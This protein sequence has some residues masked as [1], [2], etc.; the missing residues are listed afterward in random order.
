MKHARSDYNRIQDPEG[1]IPED[2][3]VFLIRGQDGNA[4]YAIKAWADL[5]ERNGADPAIVQ[6]AREWADVVNGWQIRNGLAKIPDMP[7]GV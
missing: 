6:R 1:K 4:P 2:E 5:A 3:P 7:E